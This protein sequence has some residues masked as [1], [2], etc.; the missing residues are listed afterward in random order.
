VESELERLRK[1]VEN[2]PSASAYNRL[3][4]LVRLGG[5]VAG[6]EQ[7]CRRCIKEF[8]RNGQAY[9]ILAE[10][11]MANG[12]KDEA[13]KNLITAVERDSRSYTAHR[14]L[15]DYYSETGKNPQAIQH[16]RQILTF[17]PNDPGVLQKIEQLTGKPPTASMI[18]QVAGSASQPVPGRPAEPT[19]LGNKI[20]PPPDGLGSLCMEAGVRGALIADDKGRVV[21]SKRLSGSQ[22]DLLAALAAE[23]ANAGNQ[24]LKAVGQD[25]LTTWTVSA[26][27]GQ[28]LAFKRDQSFSVVI[29]AESSVRPAMLE[30]RARQALIELGAG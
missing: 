1:K 24:A 17:K 11:E 14:M 23:I 5:D 21:A 18:R 20:L 30:I 29:L 8:P 28:V 19:P 9:V 12:K 2:F 15:A 26:N 22:E 7:V 3:A 4:E 13:A 16:L 25:G 6:A 27:Q 10:I